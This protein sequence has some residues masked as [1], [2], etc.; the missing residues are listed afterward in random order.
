MK[1]N[2]DN[3][4][5]LETY[6]KTRNIEEAERYQRILN[7]K[8]DTLVEAAESGKPSDGLSH[9]MATVEQAEPHEL[10]RVIKKTK[11]ILEAFEARGYKKEA[12]Q[13]RW[14]LQKYLK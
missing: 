12:E 11:E 8:V 5:N 14:A 7:W 4:V 1:K 3:T 6:K 10:P 9:I 13:Y 2:K